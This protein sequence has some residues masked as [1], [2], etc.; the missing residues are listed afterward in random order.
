MEPYFYCK[1]GGI[2]QICSD[3]K[4]N[5]INST[6]KTSD[7]TTWLSPNHIKTNGTGC[8]DYIP[9]KES[10]MVNKQVFIDKAKKWLRN[11]MRV[12]TTS[13]AD[14]RDYSEVDQVVSDFYT[15]EEMIENFEKAMDE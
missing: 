8:T 12:K 1:Y 10:T 9:T 3:C 4:R 11:N 5:H 13:Y 14:I 7:I 15:I 6:Y 2:G